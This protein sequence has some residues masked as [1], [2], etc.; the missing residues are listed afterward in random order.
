MTLFIV[1]NKNQDTAFRDAYHA[2]TGE[3]I[4]ALP[5]QDI[6]RARFLAGSSRLTADQAQNLLDMAAFSGLYIGSEIPD[7]WEEAEDDQE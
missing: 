7:D 5:Q 1:W 2:A 6:Q 3:R 4:Q